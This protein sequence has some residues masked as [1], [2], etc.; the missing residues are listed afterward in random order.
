MIRSVC[1][2]ILAGLLC[3]LPATT[4]KAE[5]NT[6]KSGKAFLWKIRSST[7]TVYLL[8]SLHALRNEMYPLNSSI[9]NAYEKSD[10]LVLEVNMANID[11]ME[12]NRLML[13]KGIFKGQETLEENISGETLKKLKSYLMKQGMTL[14]QVNKM[15]PWFL[16]L[17][18][19]MQEIAKLGY[20]LELGIDQYFLNKA[21]G[22]KPILGLETLEEQI[23]ILS[24]NSK[25]VQD[26]S[27]RATLEEVP[28]I[29]QLFEKALKTWMM[30]DA[31]SLSR[32]M[33]EDEV[34][35][36]KLRSQFKKMIDD[37]NIGMT[38]KIKEYLKT[39]KTYFVV[40][41]AMHIGGEQGIVKLL[42]KKS[43]TIKQVEKMSSNSN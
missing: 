29:G 2:F 24:G 12:A 26:I 9:I 22:M 37:R 5:D 11:E 39:D 21:K 3:F 8:G 19:S 34:R 15:Q 16:E 14:E 1:T 41:G 31:D 30:G 33:R 28:N 36:P 27:L 25:E 35:Y 18:I 13:E 7:A 4:V 6:N 17:T 10:T 20:S 43:Y 23:S 38:R 32:I 42:Q 40:V